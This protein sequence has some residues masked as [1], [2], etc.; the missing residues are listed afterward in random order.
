MVQIPVAN[1]LV[2]PRILEVPAGPADLQAVRR[3]IRRARWPMKGLEISSRFILRA[4]SCYPLFGV[5]RRLLRRRHPKAPTQPSKIVSDAAACPPISG[6]PPHAHPI[7]RPA[8]INPIIIRRFRSFHLAPFP[9]VRAIQVRTIER[10]V[11]PR[12]QKPSDL[13]SRRLDPSGQLLPTDYRTGHTSA[14]F[15]VR[16]ESR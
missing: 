3:D 8:A 5:S 1:K 4:N 14:H 2:E 12:K 15:P 11:L 10:S 6:L 9:S 13:D 16:S 7:T